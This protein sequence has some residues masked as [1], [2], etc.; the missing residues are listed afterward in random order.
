MLL[1]RRRLRK[2]TAC[3]RFAWQPAIPEKRQQVVFL[4]GPKKLNFVGLFRGLRFARDIAILVFGSDNT[5]IES[6]LGN[7]PQEAS[8]TLSEITQQ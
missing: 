2:R 6:F 4:S 8:V 7:N 1:G 3:G 5:R